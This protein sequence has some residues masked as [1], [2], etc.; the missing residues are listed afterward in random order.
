MLF[1]REGIKIVAMVCMLIDHVG[2]T[3]LAGEHWLVCRMLGR[4]AF[5]IFSYQLASGYIYTS[6]KQQYIKTIAIFAVISEIPY[7][8][9]FGGIINPFYQSIMLTL[10]ISIIGISII[11][12]WCNFNAHLL[13]STIIMLLVLMIFGTLGTL[14]FVD[15][16]QM[17][18]ISTILLYVGMQQPNKYIKS[19]IIFAI[20][21]WANL[22]IGG[23]Q[24]IILN[25]EVALQSFAVLSLLFIIPYIL[26]GE[27]KIL[28]G[29][30]AKVFKYVSYWFYPVHLLILS[31]IT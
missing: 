2:L 21:C 26:Q 18:V 17:G 14:T 11:D 6:N 25:R 8:L 20:I 31:M 22:S 19:T 9:F 1:T 15:Y 16:G 13:K 10:L 27:Q 7:N 23:L 24:I 28:Q 5:P 3:G 29:N 4:I 30:K 12:K